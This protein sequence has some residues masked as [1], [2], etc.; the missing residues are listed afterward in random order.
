MALVMPLLT[1]VKGAPAHVLATIG[2]VPFFFYLLHVYLIHAVA[3]GLNAL[4]GNDPSPLFGWLTNAFT[5]LEKF[6][7]LGFGLWATYVVWIAVV[8]ALYFPCRWFAGVK[9][10]RRDWWLSYL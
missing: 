7:A 1:K 2:A 4:V 3:I 6:G 9:A 8:A 10:R 5:A